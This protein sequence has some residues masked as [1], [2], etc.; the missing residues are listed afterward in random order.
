MLKVQ[1]DRKTS[2]GLQEPFFIC[3]PDAGNKYREQESI[4]L[5]VNII[6]EYKPWLDLLV[7]VSQRRTDRYIR[8]ISSGAEVGKN[9]AS[10][11][12]I[13]SSVTRTEERWNKS[14]A[15]EA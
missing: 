10:A 3:E 4:I 8:G 2:R 12:G 5:K 1:Q 6:N 11:S 13:E 9:S 7:R 14:V 15:G